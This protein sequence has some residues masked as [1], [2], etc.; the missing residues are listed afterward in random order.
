MILALDLAF[1]GANEQ[2]DVVVPLR[3]CT[4]GASLSPPQGGAGR[5]EA[6]GRAAQRGVVASGPTISIVS[7]RM[8]PRS[9]NPTSGM[10]GRHR[11][12]RA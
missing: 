9:V 6:L 12:L 11:K 1:G 2:F 10:F 8:I 5:P 7:V 3:K 4:G